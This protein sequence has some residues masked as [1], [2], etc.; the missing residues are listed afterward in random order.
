LAVLFFSTDVLGLLVARAI[1][2]HKKYCSESVYI[3]EP[4]L[5][6]TTCSHMLLL[7][8]LTLRGDLME[9]IEVVG[10]ISRAQG[11]YVITTNEGVRYELFAILPWEAVPPDFGSGDYELY[12]GKTARVR[13]ITDGGTIW[14]ATLE[15]I[16]K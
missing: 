11:R 15:E 10:L 8:L 6:V 12:L 5:G 9:D 7:S 4:Q 2:V 13:G 16:E 1:I 3:A 14:R